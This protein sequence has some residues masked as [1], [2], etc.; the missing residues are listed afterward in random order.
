[1]MEATAM[2]EAGRMR[3]Y[4]NSFELI[5]EEENLRHNKWMETALT[6]LQAMPASTVE[7]NWDGFNDSN[8]CVASSIGT[9]ETFESYE[10]DEEDGG[11]ATP[12]SQSPT[13]PAPAAATSTNRRE[14]EG[15][16][17]TGRMKPL[18]P[19]KATSRRKQVQNTSPS[20]SSGG[21]STKENSNTFKN[22][23]GKIASYTSR[24]KKRSKVYG[25]NSHRE[26]DASSNI[27]FSK[28]GKRG[29][30]RLEEETSA[31]WRLQQAEKK[32][33]LL[34]GETSQLRKKVKQL[35]LKLKV[36]NGE[37]GEL[38]D[39]VEALRTKLHTREAT[40]YSAS[41]TELAGLRD[42]NESLRA[43]LNRVRSLKSEEMTEAESILDQIQAIET[44]VNAENL[45]FRSSP[46]RGECTKQP[47]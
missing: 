38:R 32:V 42:E 45:L 20:V 25:G 30:S 29:G 33:R 47:C 7:A 41:L 43:E 12:P 24:W 18:R 28:T 34:T 35:E 8:H 5:R 10:E 36:K 13:L 1:M 6:T 23:R 16:I 19:E 27:P 37:V 31:P 22:T 15:V 40:D 2:V 44:S 21:S 17:E 39:E 14:R 46:K 4:L 11:S 26:G 9:G 3:D